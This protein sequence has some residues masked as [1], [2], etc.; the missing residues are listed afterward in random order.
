MKINNRSGQSG[1]KNENPPTKTP[2]RRAAE[3]EKSSTTP[4]EQNATAAA[5]FP[6]SGAPAA[7]VKRWLPLEANPDV[8]NQVLHLLLPS[9][10]RGCFRFRLGISVFPSSRRRHAPTAHAPSRLVQFMWGLGVPEDVGFCD[11]YGLDDEMLAMVPQPV[12]AVL[13]LYPLTSLV[14]APVGWSAP[15]PLLVV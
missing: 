10:T 3:T 14:R 5:A 11:V 12:L 8:M 9:G 15:I 1:E 7:M 4:P 6:F 13:L 2:V